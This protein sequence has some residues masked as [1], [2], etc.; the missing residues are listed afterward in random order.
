MS[1]ISA[2]D[3]TGMARAAS[4]SAALAV[5]VQSNAEMQLMVAN[6]CQPVCAPAL[7]G[8]LQMVHEDQ[9][10][11]LAPLHDKMEELVGYH[12]CLPTH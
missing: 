5:P 4:P 8:L 1:C 2:L 6:A 3:C 7:D 9:R 11:Q 12:L 10:E